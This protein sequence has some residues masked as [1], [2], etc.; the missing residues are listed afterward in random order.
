MSSGDSGRFLLSCVVA[1]A[2]AHT[3]FGRKFVALSD[4]YFHACRWVWHILV[5]HGVVMYLMQ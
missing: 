3:L 5:L 1:P 2:V 4:M